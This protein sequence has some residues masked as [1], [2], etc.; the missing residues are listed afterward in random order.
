MKN[1]RILDGD[2]PNENMEFS[3]SPASRDLRQSVRVLLRKGLTDVEIYKSISVIFGRHAV[4]AMKTVDGSD[5]QNYNYGKIFGSM[6]L[7]GGMLY[8]MKKKFKK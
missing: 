8:L 2:N 1:L 5:A 4:I 3:D 6:T 7:I